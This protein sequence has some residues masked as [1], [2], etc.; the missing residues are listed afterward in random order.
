MSRLYF[1]PG[2]DLILRECSMSNL[3]FDPVN[4]LVLRDYV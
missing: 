3:Y 4:E 2:D 1:D